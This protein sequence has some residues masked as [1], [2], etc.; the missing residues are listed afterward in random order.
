MT[1][2]MVHNTI[3]T[4]PGHLGLNRIC[5]LLP[6]RSECQLARICDAM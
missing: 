6:S 1:L 3:T 2:H 4:K 5:C